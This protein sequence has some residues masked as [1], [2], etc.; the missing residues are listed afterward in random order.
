MS[1]WRPH[2]ADPPRP[3]SL[4]RISARRMSSQPLSAEHRFVSRSPMVPTVAGPYTRM[5]PCAEGGP[6]Q[7]DTRGL[8]LR[9]ALAVAWRGVPQSCNG[10][11]ARGQGTRAVR[12]D[13][14]VRSGRVRQAGLTPTPPR[15]THGRAG[16]AGWAAGRARA[17]APPLRRGAQRQGPSVRRGRTLLRLHAPL[18]CRR[19]PRSREHFSATMGMACRL[20]RSIWTTIT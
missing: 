13:A 18:H 2:P 10:S 20:H 1:S 12:V 16:W 5:R 19:P 6:A 3:T 17:E 11:E 14:Q 9:P 7:R 4:S 15:S 8:C